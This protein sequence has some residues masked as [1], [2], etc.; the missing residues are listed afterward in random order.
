MGCDLDELRDDGWDSEEDFVERVSDEDG[1]KATTLMSKEE[2]QFLWNLAFF[3]TI[4]YRGAAFKAYYAI[5]SFITYK[6]IFM[7]DGYGLGEGNIWDTYILETREG[8]EV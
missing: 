5:R 3:L 4:E 1:N 8:D 6:G 7:A 2:G